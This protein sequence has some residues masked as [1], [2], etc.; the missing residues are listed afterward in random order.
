[1]IHRYNIPDKT[2]VLLCSSCNTEFCKHHPE[3][4]HLGSFASAQLNLPLQY[5]KRL[6]DGK[7]FEYAEIV[8]NTKPYLYSKVAFRCDKNDSIV[9]CTIKYHKE[10]K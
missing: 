4:P 8:H 7:K 2:F 1:M 5:V 6:S 3:I 10:I 9:S